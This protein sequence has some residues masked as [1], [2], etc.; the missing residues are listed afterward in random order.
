[1]WFVDRVQITVAAGDGGRGC[2]AFAQPPYIRY[3]Y[4]D[5]G[6]GGDGG[7][8]IVEADQ[9]IATLLDFR[10]RHHFKAGRGRH[11]SGNQKTGKQGEELIIR[12]PVG[13]VIHDADSGSVLR[14]LAQAGER[15]VIAEGGRGGRG[16][17][18]RHVPALTKG[19]PGQG[20][21]LRDG[22]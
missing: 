16:N 4:P 8:V 10:F 14:D 5:G 19:G 12:V 20:R 21:R 9:N 3:P 6:D 15:V 18:T 11:G 2:T 17:A 7:D 22:G 13:T 1:M